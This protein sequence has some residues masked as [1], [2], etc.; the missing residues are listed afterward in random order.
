MV[1]SHDVARLAGVSQPTV[2][3]ALRDS[4]K[5]SN[6][7]KQRVREAAMALGYATNAI[8][9]ALSVGRSTRVGLVVTD[10]HNQFY[11][12]VIAPMY[13]EL[14]RLSYELVLISESSESAPVADHVVATGLCG[15]VLTTTTVESVLP[16]R[17][18]DRGIPFVYFNRTAAVR[19]DSVTSDPEQGMRELV[20]AVVAHGHRRIGAV[21][22][23]RDTST[24]AGRESALRTCLGEHG[25]TLARQYVRY[26]PFDFDTGVTGARALLDRRDPPTVIVCAN[27]IIAFGALN[28]AVERGMRIPEDVSVVGFDDLPTSRWP[29]VQLS[30]VAYD[31]D[32][33]SRAAARLIVAR[34]EQGAD[35]PMSSAV[36]P[37]RYVRRR[38]LG[39]ART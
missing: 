7:T 23:P 20:D 12:H 9:R 27:D 19:A 3:R 28:A 2:S 33:M 25:L 11:S 24:G 39:P 29:L 10:L 15:A 1:T 31:L 34:V 5:V 14:E 17:L 16:E 21:L 8:G 4:A 13:E 22:G 26:G 32:A 30:T 18:R 37:T 6:A 35:A 38:T 36:F